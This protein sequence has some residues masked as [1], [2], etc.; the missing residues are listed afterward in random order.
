MR[1]SEFEAFYEAVA[2]GTMRLALALMGNPHEASDLTQAVF[3]RLY[4]KWA[5]LEIA[6]WQAYARGALV[7]EHA[8]SLR[9]GFRKRELLSANPSEPSVDGGFSSQVDESLALMSAVAQLPLRQRQAVVLRYLEDLP[10]ADVSKLMACTEGAVK[11]SAHDG[12]RT[13][14]GIVPSAGTKDVSRNA[15]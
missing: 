14:R 10:V 8:S 12:L 15:G 11:R 1:D 5:R 3:E 7:H 4:A 9:R 2:P 6:E 13:L